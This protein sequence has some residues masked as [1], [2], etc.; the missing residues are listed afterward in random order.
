MS[1]TIPPLD[2]MWF[3]METPESPTH[4]GA[5]MLFEKPKGRP[6]VVRE[7]VEAYRT[8]HP[9]PPFNFV[10]SL[11]GPG[12]P[13]FREVTHYDPHYHI[14]H[15]ALPAAASYDD[16][17]RLVADLS[18]PVLDRSRPLFRDW[19]IDNVPG[20]RFAVYTKVHHSITDGISGTKSLY[21][22]LSNNRRRGIR[23]PAFAAKQPVHRPRPPRALSDRLA[24]LGITVTRQTR[25]IRDVSVTT[26]KKGLG[27]LLGAEPV[28]SMPF[29]AQHAPMN[30]PLQMAR[31][32]ATLSLP[33]EEMHAVARHFGATLNDLAVTVVDEGTHR[34]LK[35]TG[36]SFPQRLVAFCPVSLRG[37]GDDGSGTK[38][39]AVFVHLGAHDASVVERVNQVM[40]AMSA[41]KQEMRSM[42][43]DAA[44]VYAVALL[45]AAELTDA[46]H[47]NRLAP[48][49]A[50]LV[51]SNVPGT[52]ERMYLNGAPLVDI[53][54][55]SA[56]AMSVGLNAT[57]TS[58]HDRMDFG[59]VGNSV[60]M[61]DLPALARYVGAA[62]HELQAAASPRRAP[63]R[64]RTGGMPA[65]A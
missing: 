41:A 61:H 51:I 65:S 11:G 59:F 12:I 43:K 23:T 4:V 32:I 10:P 48:P 6:E 29:T 57:L 1:R 39:S 44:M 24:D 8:Y 50:N 33:L 58:Y 17:L 18:E 3:V 34:Y 2:L 16:L 13:R 9:T 46:T 30:A 35:G 5:L 38:V 14:Q 36:R 49:L 62:Y 15:I 47:I 42:S 22:S 27:T 45:G 31:S 60:A 52:R 19:F 56:I 64:R 63:R 54:P 28:G 26:L 20:S 25:A 55:I 21:A 37:P 53:Y 7:I 40:S